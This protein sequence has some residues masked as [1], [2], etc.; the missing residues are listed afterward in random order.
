MFEE[1]VNEEEDTLFFS[2]DLGY[3]EAGDDTMM[4][5]DYQTNLNDFLNDQIDGTEL[6]GNDEMLTGLIEEEDEDE[7]LFE[8]VEEE[9]PSIADLKN[10][11][12]RISQ[13]DFI[14]RDLF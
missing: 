4:N 5:K 2:R 8:R 13:A 12:G 6:G 11:V 3:K 1:D 7:M 9:E 14:E 10:E